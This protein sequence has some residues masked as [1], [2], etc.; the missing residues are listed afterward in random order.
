MNTQNK[1][2]LERDARL[3]YQFL[4]FKT[5]IYNIIHKKWTWVAVVVYIFIAI[6][7]KYWL[8]TWTY[9]ASD[10]GMTIN[11]IGFRM[12]FP[13]LSIGGFIVLIVF[14]TTIHKKGEL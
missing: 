8:D 10:I 7:I 9:D 6:I 2:E 13:F 4:R 3:K 12:M 11:N 5:G 14:S 1:F